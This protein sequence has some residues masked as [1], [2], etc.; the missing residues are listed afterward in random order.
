MTYQQAYDRATSIMQA[1]EELHL[2]GFWD[3][4]VA[5]D[6]AR[7]SAERILQLA[8]DDLWATIDALVEMS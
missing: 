5:D 2:V 3:D 6:D 7:L 1:V 4:D 8:D